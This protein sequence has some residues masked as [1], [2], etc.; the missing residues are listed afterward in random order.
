MHQGHLLFTSIFERASA[1]TVL[2][3]RKVRPAS[4]NLPDQGQASQSQD[5]NPSQLVTSFLLWNL[6]VSLHLV[7]IIPKIVKQDALQ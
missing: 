2:Q 6:A 1:A 3:Q 4:I 5:S 7:L